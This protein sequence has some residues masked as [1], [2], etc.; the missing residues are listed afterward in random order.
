M[1]RSKI[2]NMT[3]NLTAERAKSR[4]KILVIPMRVEPSERDSKEIGGNSRLTAFRGNSKHA[5]ASQSSHE[6]TKFENHI[7]TDS[8]I[9]IPI[10]SGNVVRGKD[11]DGK[12]SIVES[13][14]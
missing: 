4:L 2:A 9:L 12:V 10:D 6:E 7:V 1:S 11:E 8:A 3:A 5:L 14:Y 13:A